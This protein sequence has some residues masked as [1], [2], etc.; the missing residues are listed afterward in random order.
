[1]GLTVVQVILGT[2]VRQ[3][4]DI[5]ID[6]FGEEAK[7]LWLQ[8]PTIPFYL[9]RSFSIGIVLLNLFI[10]YRIY[11]FNL[12]Y[13]KINWVIGLIILEIITGMG[14]FYLDFPFSSQ[15]LHLVIASLLFGV[16]FYLVLET[17][18]SK[19]SLKSL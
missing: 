5:R 4:I 6:I 12:G 7:N 19:T 14:M 15:P 18:K 16:Q 2:Q 9:H 13:S 11:K 8:D 1:M 3:F 17:L 10:G